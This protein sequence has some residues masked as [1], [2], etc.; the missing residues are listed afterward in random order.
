MRQSIIPGP[1]AR[2]GSGLFV[3]GTMSNF[4]DKQAAFI[5]EYPVDFNAT[6]AA[7][8]AGYSERTAYSIGHENLKKPEIWAAIEERIAE[9][10]MGPDEVLIRLGQQARA[11][12]DDFLDFHDGLK[13]P[14]I[15]LKKAKDMGLLHLVKKMKYDRDGRLELE[16]YDAQKALVHIGKMH[17]MFTDKVKHETWQDEIVQLLR[18]G[19]I[20][21]EDVQVAYPDLAA[22]LF[23][24]AGVDVSSS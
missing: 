7:I 21:P 5:R 4:T 11:S 1:A 10:S 12:F 3:F 8:R 19:Q 24:E 15:N 2:G 16:L 23:A 6:Q 20:D 22:Q 14:I 18:D 13:K 9:M 17:A